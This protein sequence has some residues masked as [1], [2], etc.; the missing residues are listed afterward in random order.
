MSASPTSSALQRKP[1]PASQVFSASALPLH[2]PALDNVLNDPHRFPASRFS[3]PDTTCSA[4]EHELFG[5]DEIQGGDKCKARKRSKLHIGGRQLKI[6]IKEETGGAGS[7]VSS[8][9]SLVRRK[10]FQALVGEEEEAVD[11][12]DRTLSSP[13]NRNIKTSKISSASSCLTSDTSPACSDPVV[14][15]PLMLLQTATLRE[16]KSNAVG[17]RKPPGGILA[18]L[19]GVQTILSTIIDLIIGVEGSTTVVSLINLSLFIDFAQIMRNNLNFVEA[20]GQ[21]DMSAVKRLLTVTIPSLL[22]LDFVSVFGL[23]I[24]FW[25]AWIAL[26]VL[27]L[28]WYL[29]MTSSYNFNRDVQGFEGQPDIFRSPKR[30]SKVANVL[31]TFL[32]MAFYLPLSKLCIDGLVWGSAFWPTD[33]GT[34]VAASASDS[35]ILRSDFCYTTTMREDDFNWAW[36]ILPL[37]SAVLI[38][39]TVLWPLHLRRVIRSMAPTVSTYDELGIKR[40]H[41]EVDA[42][43]KRLLDNDKSPLLYLY[44]AFRSAH[45]TYK[46]LYL[47]FFKLT[48]TMIV[49]VVTSQNCLWRHVDAQKMLVIEQA[50]LIG[51]QVVLLGLHLATRPFVD[52]SSNRSELCSRIAY[53]LTAVVGLLVATKV[54]GEGVLHTGIIYTI[55]IFSYGTN[56]YFTFIKLDITAHWLKRCCSRLD[57]SIDIHNPAVDLEKHIKRRVWQE[58][59]STLLLTGED[60]RMPVGSTVTFSRSAKWPPSLLFFQGTAAERHVENLK[61]VTDIGIKEYRRQLERLRGR[62]GKAL[63]LAMDAIQIQFAGPDSY[64]RPPQAPFPQGGTTWFGKTFLI[65]FPPTLVMQYDQASHKSVQLTQLAELEEFLRQNRSAEVK[66]R[67]MVRIA[68]RALDGQIV[69]CHYAAQ[70]PHERSG[71]R[72]LACSSRKA[73]RNVHVRTIYTE[74]RLKVKVQ[75]FPG[76]ESYNFSAGFDVS[77]TFSRGR[78]V[79]AE[80]ETWINESITVPASEA[81]GLDEHCHLS[82]QVSDFLAH[83]VGILNQ[84][85]PAMMDLLQRYRRKFYDEAKRKE[86][87]LAYSFLDTIFEQ[88]TLSFSELERSFE[89][90]S[91][92]EAVQSLPSRFPGSMTALYERMA[93]IRKSKVHAFWWLWWDDLYRMN[94]GDYKLLRTHRT[95]FDPRCSTAIAYRPVPRAFLE[96]ILMEKGLWRK[97]GASGFLNRGQ[98]N[99]LYFT[100]NRIVFDRGRRERVAH[101]EDAPPSY[102]SRYRSG[103]DSKRIEV[104]QGSKSALVVP[105][106]ASTLVGIRQV[107]SA[108]SAAE[109]VWPGSRFTGGGTADDSLGTIV[110]RPAYRWEQRMNGRPQRSLKGKLK[111]R[112]LQALSLK[113]FAVNPHLEGLWVF[114]EERDGKLVLQES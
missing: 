45:A 42:T 56:F 82:R 73:P 43:Y 7:A 20:S 71:H 3:L 70:H 114:V 110:D 105:H 28:V 75:D 78:R 11:D 74:G 83:N 95:T 68:L 92:I 17:P 65:L 59:L 13:A 57:F 91:Q 52:A 39:Y 31:V 67:R 46:P 49:A 15:P 18:A 86:E 81:F 6:A 23:A 4:E 87:V 40:D 51:L 96:Q 10:G 12:D 24:V 55:Q 98:I 79:D 34:G 62:E 53:V 99:R 33:L 35:S 85:R 102:D 47:I 32:L 9:R 111:D 100:L 97:E 66:T 69:R 41:S 94:A 104:G 54:E 88:S 93:Q 108:A 64:Y 36:I 2:L 61:I 101:P 50:L 19:P 84:R 14:F 22:A 38:I 8:R 58:T 25:I 72:R 80:G 90:A 1:L 16:L 44:S 103:L 37:S 76:W 48:T 106:D 112:C 5:L 109:D 21:A 107:G 29:K 63:R 89:K 60:Y 30:R 27:A 77:I 113:P 26:V